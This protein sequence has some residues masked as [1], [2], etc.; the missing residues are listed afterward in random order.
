[1]N[2]RA[3]VLGAEL[4]DHLG[5]RLTPLLAQAVAPAAQGRDDAHE[6]APQLGALD[7]VWHEEQKLEYRERH[8][9]PHPLS[10]GVLEVG[11]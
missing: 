3:K 2:D 5:E 1:M 8:R 7:S 9:H 4:Q 10:L 6:E 11:V